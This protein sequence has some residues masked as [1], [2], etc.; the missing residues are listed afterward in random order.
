[1]STIL[2]A[3]RRLEQ[4]R[5]KGAPRPL[6]EDVVVAR[7]RARGAGATWAM[8]GVAVAIGF[9]ATWGVLAGLGGDPSDP[10]AVSAAP[11]PAAP[12][13][14]PS[15]PALAA[16][17]RAP[18]PAPAAPASGAPAIAA[19]R[20]VTPRTSPSTPPHPPAPQSAPAPAPLRAPGASAP[21]GA[22]AS[23]PARA[24]AASPAPRP[25]PVAS[26]PVARRRAEDT[27]LVARPIAGRAPRIVDEP[28]EAPRSAA[29]ALPVQVVRT[30]W[31]PQ[32]DRRAA[33]VAVGSEAEREVHEGQWVGAYEV[34][35]I[36]P[37]GVLFAD[38]PLLVHRGVGER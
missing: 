28:D 38:G 20:P 23:E 32:P 5:A 7:G 31:H 37:D 8:T 30:S 29:G 4:E 15:P 21:P 19:T 2:K 18:A 25:A 13:A 1:V 27:A 12:S 11:P 33:W 22:A 6:R 35:A 36:E 10:P 24:A 16:V 26:A 14:A 3:L 9:A 34:R 17:P